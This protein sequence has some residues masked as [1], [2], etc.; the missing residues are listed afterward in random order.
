[1]HPDHAIGRGGAANLSVGEGH[2]DKSGGHH[3]SPSGGIGGYGNI[4][5]AHHPHHQHA[6]KASIVDIVIGKY[7]SPVDN[8]DH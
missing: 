6:R 2:Y 3:T 4:E 5:D 8:S 1:V 7:P